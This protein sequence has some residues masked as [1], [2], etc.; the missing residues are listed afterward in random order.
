M[1]LV[2]GVEETKSEMSRAWEERQSTWALY[3]K[4]RRGDL[5]TIPRDSDVVG[6]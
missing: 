3:P 4:G 2:L 1:H 6:C 5:D